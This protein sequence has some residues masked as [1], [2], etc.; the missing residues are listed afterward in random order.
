MP[1]GRWSAAALVGALVRLECALL[2]Y[3]PLHAH[4]KLRVFDPAEE[5]ETAVRRILESEA[6]VPEEILL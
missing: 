1:S 5:A 4:V 6:N 2:S 3:R